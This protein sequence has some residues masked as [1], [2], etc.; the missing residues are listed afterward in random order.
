MEIERSPQENLGKKERF[1]KLVRKGTNT[2]KGN[3][4]VAPGEK[5]GRGF[6][7]S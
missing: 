6:Q 1:I 5:L 2:E 7:G 4:Q 3:V